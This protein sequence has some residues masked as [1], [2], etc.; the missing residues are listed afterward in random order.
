MNAGGGN[1]PTR[2]LP[3]QVVT[4]SHCALYPASRH[5]PGIFIVTCYTKS[6]G[7]VS[8]AAKTRGRPATGKALSAAERMRR[9]RARRS[10]AGLRAVVKWVPSQNRV[11][12]AATWSDHHN[13]EM[14]SLAMHALMATKINRDEDLLEIPRRNLERWRARFETT[15]P[16][17]WYEWRRI[18]ERPW[19]EIVF[20]LV[21][22]GE[23]ATRLRQSSPFVGILTAKQRKQIN[24]AFRT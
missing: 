9:M 19:K 2:L 21:D 8:P 12:L 24:D 6:M 15:P 7:T 22:T 17:W 3:D 20:Y 14:R 16:R 18:L 11:E 4:G 13:H 10:A 1:D 23:T 5:Q